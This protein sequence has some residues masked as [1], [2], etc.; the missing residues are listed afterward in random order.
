MLAKLFSRNTPGFRLVP[1][2]RTCYTHV[3]YRI[4]SHISH[5]F[6]CNF[7]F[8]LALFILRRD[9]RVH[10]YFVYANVSLTFSPAPRLQ[11]WEAS[12]R[13]SLQ[14]R[15]FCFLQ[16]PLCHLPARFPSGEKKT[17]SR[18]DNKRL[19]SKP[20][21]ILENHHFLNRMV[22]VGVYNFPRNA[23]SFALTLLAINV[24]IG[25]R[26]SA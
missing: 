21:S 26:L 14:H 4:F 5:R 23:P 9:L 18:L 13:R 25:T 24:S 20:Q 17:A 19:D 8:T 16:L 11:R 3:L 6:Y 12:K 2:P 22:F 15:V 10:L 7:F 1:V